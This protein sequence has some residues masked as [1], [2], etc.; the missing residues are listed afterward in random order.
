MNPF[1]VAEAV[2]AADLVVVG[3]GLYGLTI[4]ERAASSGH[5]VC[6]LERRDHLGGNAFSY[7][8]SETGIEVHK[9]GSHL[10][11]TSNQRVWDY[12]NQFTK[13]T[14]YRHHVFTNYKGKIY[15]MPINLL[16]ISSFFGRSFSPKE[17][18]AFIEQSAVGGVS[19]NANH[20][21]L[22]DKAIALIGQQLYEAFIY[23]YTK[24]Q[25]NTDPRNLPPSIITRLP[26]RYDFNSRYFSDT[27]EGLPSDGYFAWLQAM[28]AHENISL[29][30]SV[31]Y[32]DIS[33]QVLGKKPLVYT[34]PLDRFFD[35]EE[36]ELSWRTLDFDIQTEN[37]GDFQGTSVMNYADEG[38]PFTRIHEFKHL[39]PERE[40]SPNK[41]IVMYEF[42]RFAGR[43]DEPYYPV[44]ATSDR[45]RLSRYRDRAK[46][47]SGV[48]FGGRLGSYQYLDMHMAIASALTSW[49][50]QISPYLQQR[51]A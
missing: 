34:G 8:D 42:S 51:K 31:D 36:G 50:N 44:N 30:L 23:G 33:Q 22:E 12:V 13:F 26:V 21:N 5:K 43:D 3:S 38:V 49:E 18:M 39:H 20:R 11:H 17:A 10:F 9:Y 45:K 46:A 28:A 24:K 32:F 2:H 41:T 4:A 27:W 40:H 35:Y 1:S 47:I 16:T 25:W 7:M 6:I 29:F 15:P 14:D 19:E 37:V 48:F